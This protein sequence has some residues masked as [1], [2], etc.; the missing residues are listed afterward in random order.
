MTKKVLIKNFK[1]KNLKGKIILL[2]KFSKII[3]KKILE[4]T[5]KIILK[6]I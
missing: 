6:E 2:K 5:L 3:L 1:K 4:K